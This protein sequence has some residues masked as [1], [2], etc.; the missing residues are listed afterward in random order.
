MNES[1]D[2]VDGDGDSDGW[3][4]VFVVS[5]FKMFYVVASYFEIFCCYCLR[6]F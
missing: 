3:I 6:I 2:D 4:D 1:D 5:M